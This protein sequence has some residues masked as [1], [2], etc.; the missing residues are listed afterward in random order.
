MALIRAAGII[1]PLRA[2]AIIKCPRR[3]NIFSRV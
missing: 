3:E 2:V 1:D